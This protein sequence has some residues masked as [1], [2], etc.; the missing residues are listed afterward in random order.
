MGESTA[1]GV[2]S[3][4]AQGVKVTFVLTGIKTSAPTGSKSEFTTDCSK[5]GKEWVVTDLR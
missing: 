5:L 3:D 2:Y 4:P 1:S